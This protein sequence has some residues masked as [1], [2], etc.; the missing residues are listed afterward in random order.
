MEDA[1]VALI[2]DSTAEAAA[3]AV[4]TDQITLLLRTLPETL[5]RSP[6]TQQAPPVPAA[7]PL[8]YQAQPQ[9][10]QQATPQEPGTQ[11]AKI[12]TE[13]LFNKKHLA[14]AHQ[15]GSNDKITHLQPMERVLRRII[16][17]LRLA[18]VDTSLRVSA[19][20]ADASKV[21]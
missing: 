11:I 8:G 18:V 4:T 15:A 1:P 17:H 20:R 10:Q 6:L 3:T 16:V 2:T 9:E 14:R 12:A 21:W 5:E 19:G 13:I 7:F